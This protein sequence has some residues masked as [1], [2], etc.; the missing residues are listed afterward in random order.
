MYDSPYTHNVA[1]NLQHDHI[2]L[3]RYTLHSEIYNV[4]ISPVLLAHH[5]MG[6]MQYTAHIY[7]TLRSAIGMTAH[8]HRCLRSVCTEQCVYVFSRLDRLFN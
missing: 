7:S 4:D 5:N 8:P 3:V 1:A 2:L 6:D